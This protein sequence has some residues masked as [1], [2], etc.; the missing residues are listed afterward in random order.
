MKSKK[1]GKDD[2]SFL[3]YQRIIGSNI[4]RRRE[5]KGMTQDRLAY[6]M[7]YTRGHISHIES[8]QRGMSV[9]TLLSFCEMLDTDCNSLVNDPIS[10]DKEAAIE[11]VCALLRNRPETYIA[12]VKS[13]I[14]TLDSTISESMA[15]N[16]KRPLAGTR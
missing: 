16:D 3:A 13:F 10:S 1:G 9:A 7:N 4:K 14:S 5:E 11:E 8:G 2:S 6:L 15:A 12:G